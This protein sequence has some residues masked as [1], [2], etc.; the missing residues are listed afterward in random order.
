MKTRKRTLKVA[1]I[2]CASFLAWIPSS[3]ANDNK[4]IITIKAGVKAPFDGVLYSKEAH[5][6]LVSRTK[7]TD[8]RYKLKCE[9]QL[10]RLRIELA[11]DTRL[12]VL[13]LAAEKAA[14]LATK[15]LHKTSKGLLLSE[16]KKAK[17][18]PWYKSGA[19]MFTVGVVV[20]LTLGSLAVWAVSELR[21]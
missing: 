9:L 8:D 3:Y 7:T 12:K 11:K 5:A 18:T 6:L 1:L 17:T 2:I 16:L 14:H 15:N 13:E 20:T 10:G 19:F 21:K 4:K